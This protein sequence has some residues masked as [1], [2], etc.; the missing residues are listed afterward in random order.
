LPTVGVEG[1]QLRRKCVILEKEIWRSCV[2]LR[3][4]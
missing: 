2:A 1:P 3:F 4:M